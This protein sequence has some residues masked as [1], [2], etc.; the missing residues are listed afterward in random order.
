MEEFKIAIQK[1]QAQEREK[2]KQEFKSELDILTQKVEKFTKE[3]AKLK[4]KLESIHTKVS[5][6]IISLKNMVEVEE[7]KTDS[8]NL[9]RSLRNQQLSQKEELEN[10]Q[11]IKHRIKYLNHD[12]QIFSNQLPNIGKEMAD[13]YR[14][15]YNKEP[16]KRDEKINDKHTVPVC[17]YSKNDWEY[18]DYLIKTSLKL[19]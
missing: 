19:E 17:I 18:M 13:Y 14:T 16:S 12:P 2:I 9:R 15:S 4:S 8:P 3:Y 5:A 11:S 10:C 1:F 6:T 7:K